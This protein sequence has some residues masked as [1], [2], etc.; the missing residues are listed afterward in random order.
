MLTVKNP[1]K[2]ETHKPFI[3]VK[4]NHYWKLPSHKPMKISDESS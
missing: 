3:R 2:N 4:A 1:N